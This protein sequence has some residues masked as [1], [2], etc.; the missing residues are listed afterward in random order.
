MADVPEGFGAGTAWIQ[1]VCG[2]LIGSFIVGL[3]DCRLCRFP[4][5]PAD[6]LSAVARH[7]ECKP[8][9]GDLR[10]SAQPLSDIS[11]VKVIL[12]LHCAYSMCA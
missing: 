7:I 3:F 5:T 1:R 11:E 10:P 6:R 12:M 2:G 8:A 9:M 4:W